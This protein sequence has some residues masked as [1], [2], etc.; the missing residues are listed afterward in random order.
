MF[1]LFLGGSG[2]LHSLLGIKHFPIMTYD[3]ENFTD[4]I[5]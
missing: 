5:T 4:I 2:V 3:D 1:H